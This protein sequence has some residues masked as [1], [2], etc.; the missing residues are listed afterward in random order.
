MRAA[1]R[2][3]AVLAAILSF[4]VCEKERVFQ[5]VTL[6]PALRSVQLQSNA[7]EIPAEGTVDVVFTV[8]DKKFDFSLASDVVL[9]PQPEAFSLTEVRA[10]GD[11]RYTAVLSDT[12][13]GDEYEY[14]VDTE[15]TV[16]LSE[17]GDYVINLLQ[18]RP[19]QVFQDTGD[20]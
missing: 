4:C 2:V 6:P 18:C 19:L 12:G 20:A 15:F 10:S 3:L 16:N 8:D 1:F 9:S 13:K 14:P 5:T 11:G 7:V 17:N